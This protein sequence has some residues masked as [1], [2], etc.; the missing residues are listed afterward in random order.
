MTSKTLNAKQRTD[1]ECLIE[2]CRQHV[3]D[4]KVMEEDKEFADRNVEA[5]EAQP[6][7]VRQS[8]NV[9]PMP[10]SY[11][12]NDVDDSEMLFQGLSEGLLLETISLLDQS[13]EQDF[14]NFQKRKET[15]LINMENI[16]QLKFPD[17]KEIQ[18]M[19]M[20]TVADTLNKEQ[21]RF[22]K[23]RKTVRRRETLKA[24][25]ATEKQID[26]VMQEQDLD[27]KLFQET[28]N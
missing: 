14:L 17:D 18:K 8:E 5:E 3:E 10:S 12:Q 2:E 15:L 9:K 4:L 21:V 7:T 22:V 11:Q 1:F 26:E 16:S 19:V 24:K 25:G 13:D 28:D 23:Q 27:F 20:K 6:A